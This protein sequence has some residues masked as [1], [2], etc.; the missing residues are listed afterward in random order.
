MDKLRKFQ[1]I[2]SFALKL[3]AI[4]TMTIDHVGYLLSFYLPYNDPKI[5]I[6]RIIGRLALPLFCL[7]IA[8]GVIHRHNFKKYILRLG[9]VGSL[10]STAYILMGE[11][12][13]WS[14][15]EISSTGN[16]FIDLMLGAVA[17]FCLRKKEWYYK[18][19]AILPIA[20]AFA[21]EIATT[22]ECNG[23]V[24]IIWW[25]PYFLRTQ[26]GVYGVS[27]IL[28]FY[29]AYWA[30][31]AIIENYSSKL[32]LDKDVVFSSGSQRLITN[33]FLI[34]A[35]A[36]GT[37]MYWICAQQF[38]LNVMSIQLYALITSALLLFYNGKQGYNK[39]W[40][41]YGFYLYYPL[42]LLLLALIYLII[43]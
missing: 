17:V 7:G 34:A 33:L 19:I 2:N 30:S 10:I 31:N 6:C 41:Q 18:I 9:I 42:H 4:I 26:Y 37:F 36:F 1:F 43:N 23:T 22:C 20:F 21:S 24:A 16:I 5:M 25:I 32:G 27:L 35:L 38:N 13:I 11:M 29:F 28:L 39:K 15:T 40:L 3:I 14:F 12:N 8:E